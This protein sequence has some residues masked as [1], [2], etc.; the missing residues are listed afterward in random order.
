M[1]SETQLLHSLQA[2]ME[3]VRFTFGA[4]HPAQATALSG[5]DG[6]ASPASTLFTFG[7]AQPA[8]AAVPNGADGAA[9]PVSTRFT[10]GAA[11]PAQAAEGVH[12]H[13]LPEGCANINSA[14]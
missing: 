11:H 5:A 4:A 7:A 2:G 9:S 12:S 3:H 14:I 13:D 6:A 1:R 10:F 8:Q